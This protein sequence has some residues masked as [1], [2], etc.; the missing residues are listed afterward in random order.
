MVQHTSDLLVDL[1]AFSTNKNPDLKERTLA[2][3]ER[4]CKTC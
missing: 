3:K 2:N 1:F 4:I